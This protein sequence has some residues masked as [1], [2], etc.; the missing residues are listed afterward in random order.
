VTA[1]RL[2]PKHSALVLVDLMT[3]VIALDTAPVPAVEIAQRCAEL[4]VAVRRR[5]WLVVYVR[6]ER[7]GVD[8]QPPGGE[9][10]PGCVLEPGDVEIVKRTWGAFHNTGLD[11]VLRERG[12]RNV[13]LGGIAT[14]FGVE[15]TGRSAHEHGYSVVFVSDAMAG[16]HGY[17]H[18]FSVDYVFPRLGVVCTSRELLDGLT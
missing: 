9:L 16:L 12:I 13:V 8:E 15:S 6:A 5:G 11:A 17:A 2:D 3:R 10:V 14:N 1:V 18:G 7:P 4:A